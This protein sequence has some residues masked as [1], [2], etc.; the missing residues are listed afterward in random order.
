MLCVAFAAS[1]VGPSAIAQSTAALEAERAAVFARMLDAPADR[2]LMAQYARLSISLRD[3][4]AAAAT[5]E[6]LIDIDPANAT[7]RLELAT[8]YFAMGN[9]PL[10]EFHLDAAA[11]SGAL[12][13]EQLASADAYRGA[14]AERDEASQLSGSIAAGLLS[15]DGDVGVLGTGALNWSVDL[16]D[17]NATQWV[18]QI[19]AST[20]QI[21]AG[22]GASASDRQTLRVRSGPRFQLT[23]EAFGPRVQPYLQFEAV[24]FPDV[25]G[26]NYRA[27]HVGLAYQNPHSAEWTSFAD[28]SIGWGELDTSG[29]GIDF[30]DVSLGVTYRPSRE[31]FY[32]LTL[33]MGSEDT[34]TRDEDQHGLRVDYSRDFE[35]PAA[36]A[37]PDWQ[38]GAFASVDWLDVTDSGVAQDQTVTATGLSLRAYLNDDVYVETRGT[39]V[40]RDGANASDETV[41]SM[42]LGLEF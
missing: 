42:Q 29:A 9:Y 41:F 6:R 11:A 8:A 31:A 37:V 20:Y 34:S 30:H 23:G 18:T 24:R 5:L 10:A 25:S 28:A 19:G 7:A 4:E 33:S 26:S 21:D 14:A 35:G 12:S 40:A 27:T 17:A 15:A 32:R 3:F 36:L 2:T 22:P 39:H 13:P 38:A 1:S 16:G